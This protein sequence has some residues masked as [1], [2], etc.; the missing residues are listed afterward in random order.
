LADVRDLLELVAQVFARQVD[1][2]DG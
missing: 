2:D 1:L